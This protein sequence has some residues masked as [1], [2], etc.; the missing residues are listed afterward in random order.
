MLNTKK[1]AREISDIKGLLEKYE[2]FNETFEI[3]RQIGSGCESKVYNILH[4]KNKR[5]FAMKHILKKRSKHFLNELKISS[6]L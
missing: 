5:E 3:I 4:K 6:K 1:E 2:S